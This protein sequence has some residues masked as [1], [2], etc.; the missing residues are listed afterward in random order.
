MEKDDLWG[1]IRQGY[2][3]SPRKESH[4]VH[5]Q[6]DWYIRHPEHISKVEQHAR[7]YL[8]HIVEELE[9]RDMPLEL[10][11]LPVVESAYRPYAHSPGSAA[12][13]WQFIPSTGKMYG[14]KQT[15]WYDGRRDILASTDAALD[16]LESL[17]EQFDGDWELALAAYNAGSGAVRRAI[18]KNQRSGKPTDY[19]SLDLPGE[20]KRYV[21]RL[22]ALAEIVQTPEEYGIRLSRIPDKPFFE[23]VE[24][25]TQLDLPLAAELAGIDIEMLYRL[26][27]GYNRWATDPQGPHRILLPLERVDEFNAKLSELD[28]D[29]RIR[30]ARYL[31]QP[32]DT[33]QGIARKHETTVA[34]LKQANHLDSSLIK[35]GRAL[36]IP[37]AV[38][39]PSYLKLTG[40]RHVAHRG[41]PPGQQDYPHRAPRGFTVGDRSQL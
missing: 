28:P 1:R 39:D 38:Q 10:A 24:I 12:G 40:L 11:L 17:S 8:H 13:I 15:W 27:P 5:R 23:S 29:Q 32:G 14:L 41:I 20:T 2:Q 36:L 9:K 19:W 3:L 25:D 30:W 18:R 33:L 37:Q 16:Y 6:L 7:P 21:P 35:A 4:R 34:V 22:L 26:N 31:I